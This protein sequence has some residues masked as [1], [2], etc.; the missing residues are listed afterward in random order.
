MFASLDSSYKVKEDRTRLAPIPR[1]CKA[2]ALR[3]LS[4]PPPDFLLLPLQRVPFPCS[5]R[6][7]QTASACCYGCRWKYFSTRWVSLTRSTSAPSP[8]PAQYAAHST[9]RRQCCRRGV[10]GQRPDTHTHAPPPHTHHRTRH[11]RWIKPAGVTA[12]G[13][14]SVTSSGSLPARS[15]AR[16]TI[17]PGYDRACETT[18]G[19]EASY[20]VREVRHC[21]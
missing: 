2:A 12:C 16:R 18:P 1:T 21:C 15:R 7:L 13:V 14:G 8:E 19:S 9:I 5:C 4:P 6:H 3:S 10:T 11:R 17:W 20:E